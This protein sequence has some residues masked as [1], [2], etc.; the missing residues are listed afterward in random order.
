MAEISDEELARVASNV[1]VDP[2]Y[3]ALYDEDL[4]ARIV[5]ELQARRAAE[6]KAVEE[7]WKL[8]VLLGRC[9]TILGNM[10]RENE[11]KIAF[12]WQRW[13]IN[14]EPLRADA[15]NILPEIEEYF[16]DAA[17]GARND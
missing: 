11:P 12:K 4:I 1:R 8:K 14:H 13:P 9:K 7:N 17:L 2:V 6:A 16:S 10:A 5:L 3:V 15:K